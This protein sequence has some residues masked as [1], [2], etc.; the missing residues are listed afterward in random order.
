VSINFPVNW[1]KGE[2]WGGEEKRYKWGGRSRWKGSGGVKKGKIR[3]GEFF[4]VI[5]HPKAE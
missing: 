2:I 4:L 1:K 5:L 3:T